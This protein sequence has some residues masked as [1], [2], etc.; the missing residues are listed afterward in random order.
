MA[1]TTIINGQNVSYNEA[2]CALC[3]YVPIFSGCSSTSYGFKT[4]QPK[5]TI[6]TIARRNMKT[7][8]SPY[9]RITKPDR[10]SG[11]QGST[12]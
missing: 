5:G 3:V 9:R 2:A 11:Q 6:H 4:K 1:P 12:H 7:I 10:S 8:V